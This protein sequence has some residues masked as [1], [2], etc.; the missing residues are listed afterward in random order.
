MD[1]A[2]LSMITRAFGIFSTVMLIAGCNLGGGQNNLTVNITSPSA[3][4]TIYAGQSVDFECSVSN[5]SSPYTYQWDFGGGATDSPVQ[6]PGL[7]SFSTAGTYTVNLTVTDSSGATAQD[8]VVVTVQPSSAYIVSITSPSGDVTISAGQSVNFQSTVFNGTS[9]YTYLWDFD[10]GAT[11]S[12]AQNPGSI[13]FSTA[14]T[15]TVTLTVTDGSGEQKQAS[16]IVTV[17]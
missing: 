12:T 11:N 6:N 1:K 4:T 2:R 16:V 5:G 8:S 14:G 9:P 7:I 10:G 3:D 15:Y 17:Q 13:I